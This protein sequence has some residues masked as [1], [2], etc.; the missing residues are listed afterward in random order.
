MKHGAVHTEAHVRETH[1]CGQW[2][3][4]RWCDWEQQLTIKTTR[5]SKTGSLTCH[6]VYTR[7]CPAL[8]CWN[9]DVVGKDANSPCMFWATEPTIALR[10]KTTWR[11]GHTEERNE[12]KG[13]MGVCQ[14]VQ[15]GTLSWESFK[16]LWCAQKYATCY[17]Y[18]LSSLFLSQG[19]VMMNGAWLA[20]KWENLADPSTQDIHLHYILVYNHK[21]STNLVNPAS[22]KTQQN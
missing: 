4:T 2:K 21:I 18:T 22:S 9:A 11:E 17:T 8:T 16:R 5:G 14:R 1:T 7:V 6:L 3:S 20:G 19:S 12:Q 10:E 15:K 13:Q